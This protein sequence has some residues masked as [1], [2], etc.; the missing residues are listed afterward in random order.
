MVDNS[1]GKMF[2]SKHPQIKEKLKYYVDSEPAE[3]NVRVEDIK[4]LDP[5]MG[6][7]HILVYAFDVFIHIY[8]AEGYSERDAAKL[9]LENNI[10]GLDIDKRAYQL[11]YFAL[12]MKA[13]QYNRRIMNSEVKPQIYC[14]SG[15][16]DGEEYGSIL[17]I[18]DLEP[19]PEEINEVQLTLFDESYTTK[20][21]TWNFRRILSQRYDVVVT[22]PPYLGSS[23]FSSKLQ[24]YVNT[25]YPDVK[26]D[27]S[28][29]MYKHALQDLSKKDGYVAFITTSSWMYLSSFEKF[30]TNVLKNY[31]FDS[32]VDF[33]SE[34]FEGKVGHNLILAWVN[35]ISRTDKKMTSIRLVDY[36]YSRR[37]EKEPEFFNPANRYTASADNF[38]KIQGSPIAYWV[39]DNMIKSFEV[40]ELLEKVADARLGM[41]TANN[42]LFVRY[43]YEVELCAIGFGCVT[44]AESSRSEKT[45][46]PYNSGGDYRMWYGNFENV[47]NWKNDGY[48]IRNYS[49]NS[50]G[51]VNSHNYNLDYIFKESLTWSA[52]SSSNFGIRYSPEGSLFDNAGSSLF[53]KKELIYYLQGFLSSKI[54]LV[55]LKTLNPTMNYQ[56]GNL[57]ALPVIINI[58]KKADIDRLVTQN[59]F[60]SR[61][62]WDAF[63]TSWD[64]T[65]HPLISDKITVKLA[66]DQWEGEAANRFNTLKANEEELNRI[67]I[68]IYGLQDELTPE[69]E[70]KDVTVRR[71]D[72][73]REIR[74]LI[75]YAV[76]CM[77]GR[78]SLDVDGLAYAGGEW[79]TNKY[80]SFIP[81]KDNILPICDDEY[82]DDDI[83][84]RFIT[85][86]KIAYGED[87]L[88]ENLKFIA[89]ALGG[90]GTPREVIRNYFLNDFY[91]DHL[92][93]YQKRPIYWLFDS[94]KKNGF[95]ALIYMHR[96]SRDLLAKMRT[97]Y[98]HE[99]QERYR[100]QLSHITNALNTATGAERARLLKQQEKLSEQAQEISV[101][102]EKVHHLADQHIAIDLDDGVKRNY[103]I[104]ADVLAKI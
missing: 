71:A 21:N 55:F 72:L 8:I 50:D 49:K 15:Y 87:T 27:L 84:G 43:W 40:G 58:E 22:N 80:K 91:K 92:K 67:F 54:T 53:T 46:F 100:T 70:E 73:G 69:V 51:K 90:K 47:V 82:F 60:H 1:L 93:V 12:M 45:W 24:E 86:V 68:D 16:A 94:G 25:H 26:S 2:A 37:D 7:G 36:C 17:K 4:L 57:S 39:S 64:F 23:R 98:V 95:K 81:D 5:C 65:R 83:V 61:S 42:N 56:P 75:S 10:Y 88:E 63:E 104:F 33:G 30:R 103:E 13:R 52:L 31:D 32:L 6:S 41:A 89:D 96:Y 14:P 66:F 18:S 78:Y 35:R 102:E 19:K 20:L 29:V 9:I 44:R 34:L 76:G 59:I 3:I 101:Y 79:D 97:D 62:D 48:D 38:T 11:A 74:S 85:F 28:M 77:L 99:Q